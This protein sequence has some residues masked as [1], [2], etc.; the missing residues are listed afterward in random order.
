MGKGERKV[1]RLEVLAI[2][3]S[4]KE[5]DISHITWIVSRVSVNSTGV[6]CFG[7]IKVLSK[8]RGKEFSLS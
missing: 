4:L 2:R 3:E 1:E 7:G 8:V 6:E 5:R